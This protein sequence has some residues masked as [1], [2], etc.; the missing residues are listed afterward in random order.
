MIIPKQTDIKDSSM[1]KALLG[2]YLY[3]VFFLSMFLSFS[4]SQR[5]YTTKRFGLILNA[6][7]LEQMGEE[8]FDLI[9]KVDECQ[10]D[11]EKQCLTVKSFRWFNKKLTLKY[12]ELKLKRRQKFNGITVK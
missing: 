1:G 3:Q 4:G 5:L 2:I 12:S 10:H 8:G 6:D 7:G 11:V 9:Q